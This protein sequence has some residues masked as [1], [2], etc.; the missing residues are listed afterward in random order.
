MANLDDFVKEMVDGELCL[1]CPT[2][3]FKLRMCC[4]EHPETHESKDGSCPLMTPEGLCVEHGYKTEE[5]GTHYCDTCSDYQCHIFENFAI[6]SEDNPC[7]VEKLSEAIEDE[8]LGRI[9][10][11]YHKIEDGDF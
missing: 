4:Y 11:L 2:E 8:N 3:E 6:A 9:K 1:Y 10:K 7:L 5:G